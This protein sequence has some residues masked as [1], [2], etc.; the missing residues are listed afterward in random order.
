[1]EILVQ[2][3]AEHE[4]K[5]LLQ[6]E[7]RMDMGGMK[8]ALNQ[9][10]TIVSDKR[11]VCGSSGCPL[12]RKAEN[13]LDQLFWSA[14]LRIYNTD[15]GRHGSG[16]TTSCDRMCGILINNQRKSSINIILKQLLISFTYIF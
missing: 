12:L 2:A 6:E 8:A 11:T 3:F 10:T 13:L 16:Y 14:W 5:L 7:R 4:R 15:F 1:M 9:Y